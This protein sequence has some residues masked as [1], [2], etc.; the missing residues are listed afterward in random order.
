[1]A[2]VS[3]IRIK[4]FK[5]LI[6][7]RSIR[8]LIPNTS[9]SNS[10]IASG[11]DDIYKI[12]AG[13][14]KRFVIIT[15][16]C[17]IHETS[18]AMEYAERLCELRKKYIDRLYIIMRV[19]FEKP[20]TTI[21]WKGLI[22]DPFI[23]NSNN[24]EE[25]LKLARR[26][27]IDIAE[28]CIPT[29]TEILDPIIAG[30]IGE[31]VSWIAIGARTS[32]SQTHR[33]MASGLSASVGFKNSTDGNLEVALNAIE[34]AKYPHSFVGIDD[35]GN[36]CIINTKGNPYTHIVLRG[37]GGK[38]NYHMEDIEECEKELADRKLPIRILVDCSHDNSNK[39]YQKQNMVVRDIIAQKKFGNKSIFGLMLESN[40]CEGKQSIPTD[41]SKL[42]HGVSISDGCIGWEE[43]EELIEMLYKNI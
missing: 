41:L 39:N 30:Y 6:S 31:L 21:G 28:T 22:N 5:K 27:L 20:R 35:D 4:A 2:N 14:D 43:T 38:P 17:S 33:Q 42:K 37:G 15:G 32:E 10:T 25:G 36:S 19:Y 11:R 9:K 12:L 24:I 23:N 1:M 8:T 34:S 16:P 40:L 7:P 29:A 26:L 3:N 13:K 18:A